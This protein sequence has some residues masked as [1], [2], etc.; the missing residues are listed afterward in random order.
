[1]TLSP[2]TLLSA[3]LALSLPAAAMAEPGSLTIGDKA[4]KLDIEHWFSTGSGFD[5]VSDFEPGRVYV[6]EFWATWCGPCIGSMPSLAELQEK[7]ADK[8]VQIVSISDEPKA[9]VEKFL[10]RKLPGV[11]EP[12]EG[13]SEE[14]EDAEESAEPTTYGELTGA[15]SLTTDPD[16]S[17]YKDYMEAAFQNGIPCC[18]IVGKTGEVEWIGHPMLMKRDGILDDVLDGSFDRESFKQEFE[19]SQKYDRLQAKVFGLLEE[20]EGRSAVEA[21]EQFGAENDDAKSNPMFKRMRMIAFQAAGDV[22]GFTRMATADLEEASDP[23][24]TIQAARA[25]G[26]A[27][28]GMT[29]PKQPIEAAVKAVNGVT[30]DLEGGIAAFAYDTLG[31]LHQAAGDLDAAIAAQKKAVEAAKDEPRLLP[32]LKAGLKRI[33]AAKKEAG[34]SD[35]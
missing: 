12:E 4:P 24:S 7:Y 19:D 8:G 26:E 23:V 21:L 6:V 29:L 1:M 3:A 13:E 28:M 27:A 34:S 11:E 18:F 14:G 35:E 10:D 20:G 2:R 16:E 32:R 25:I 33:E 17:T 15:Y 9:T 30:E 31:L 5:K 22:D